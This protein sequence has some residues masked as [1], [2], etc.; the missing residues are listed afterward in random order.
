MDRPPILEDG[1]VDYKSYSK[2]IEI[3]KGE[4]IAIKKTIQ[5]GVPGV[6][7]YGNI[8]EVTKPYDI[9]IVVGEDVIIN[10]SV[11]G[12]ETYIAS[13]TGIL[14][15]SENSISIMTTLKINSDICLATGNINFSRDIEIVG[16]V[17][18]MF[19]VNCGGDLHLQGN[20]ENGSHI[21][22]KGSLTVTEGIIGPNTTIEVGNDLYA[23]Y[24]QDCNI[25]V[26][27]SI[28][29]LNSVYHSYIFAKKYITVEGQR[30][31]S[32]THGS[33]VGGTLNSLLGINIDSV[34]SLGSGAKL[35]CGI[36]L[37]L[38]SYFSKLK[39]TI[40]VINS[41][42]IKLQNNLGININNAGN[43]IGKLSTK[44]REN[45]KIK[46]FELKQLI[47]KKNKMD[48]IRKKIENNI[49]NKDLESIKIVINK[50]ILDE[51]QI[52]IGKYS[53]TLKNSEKNV[54]FSL[55]KERVIKNPN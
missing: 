50:F 5:E 17:K 53:L 47:V 54:Y 36:D 2:F 43:E 15:Y 44:E 48:S 23:E 46:L 21:K 6:D 28:H 38:K 8:L 33:V 18:S 51:T 25:N 42:I 4:K 37:Q 24:I 14:Q 19:S 3:Q 29:I 7:V 32:K 34:G 1:S 16:N 55:L 45:L 49:E 41:K 12:I 27:G 22:C 11:D 35:V 26:G 31:K 52:S 9:D 39:E 10:D 30:N 20:I 40:L 13:Q